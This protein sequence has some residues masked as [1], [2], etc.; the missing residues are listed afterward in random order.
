MSCKMFFIL[1]SMYIYIYIRRI[2]FFIYKYKNII[3]IYIFIELVYGK[4]LSPNSR[5]VVPVNFH[6]KRFRFNTLN[7]ARLYCKNLAFQF[8]KCSKAT[9]L[10]R[11]LVLQEPG[12]PIPGLRL[13]SSFT[14]KCSKSILLHRKF[15]W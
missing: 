7:E 6:Q 11:K 15:V 3:Y 13:H 1:I 14:R 4:N 10:R 2:Y 9:H 8:Q 5:I 12:F